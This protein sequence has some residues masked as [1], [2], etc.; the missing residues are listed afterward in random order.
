MPNESI[1]CGWTFLKPELNL[2]IIYTLKLKQ[3]SLSQHLSNVQF[4]LFVE[5]KSVS[6]VLNN[7]KINVDL[8]VYA[9]RCIL[10]TVYACCPN[11]TARY[12]G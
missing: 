1:K 10:H 9:Q 7:G 3:F 8:I 4:L 11:N 2:T 12:T 5:F 6:V